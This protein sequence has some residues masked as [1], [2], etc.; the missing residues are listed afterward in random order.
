MKAAT[1]MRVP[2]AAVLAL[3]AGVLL[4]RRTRAAAARAHAAE[5]QRRG[6]TLASA[7]VNVEAAS[8]PG[9]GVRWPH[10][11]S[12]VSSGERAAA[13]A[14]L[15]MRSYARLAHSMWVMLAVSAALFKK[16]FEQ[17][18]PRLQ[19]RTGAASRCILLHHDAIS[20]TF[21]SCLPAAA[22]HSAC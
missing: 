4:Q 13:T 16:L 12:A 10:T 11:L 17:A 1:V 8:K 5:H 20:S 22:R 7:C 19:V 15:L 3:A 14:A 6:R 9:L 21:A 18:L 2:R